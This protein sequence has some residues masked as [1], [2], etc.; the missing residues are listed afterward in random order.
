ME[1]WL[2]KLWFTVIFAFDLIARA[3]ASLGLED[4]VT[5]PSIVFNVIS[6]KYVLSY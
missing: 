5:S 1:F 2:N 3:I 6:A 4:K